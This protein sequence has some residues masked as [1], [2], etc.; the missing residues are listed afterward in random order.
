MNMNTNTGASAKVNV[1]KANYRLQQKV[2]AGPL[3]EKSLKKSQEVIDTNE[4]DFGPLGLGILKKLE[5]RLREAQNSS[6]SMQEIK[7]L[8]TAPVME[9]K[10][11]AS[12]FH[13]T[14]IGNLANIML[15]FLEGLMTMDKDAVDIVKAHHDT[16][17]MIL[18]R[19][20]KGDGGAGGKALMVEL[21]QACDRYRNKRLS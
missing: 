21:Q 5:D 8:L 16:L 18:V 3:D 2:G 11:N 7:Q 10:A 6:I 19:G 1:I 17:H 9:L 12:I 13:Y 20:M 4:V 14:L 15:N